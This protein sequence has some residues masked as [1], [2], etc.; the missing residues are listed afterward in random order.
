MSD[1]APDASSEHAMYEQ[2][3]RQE[4]AGP[5][6]FATRSM[7]E[8]EGSSLTA[9]LDLGRLGLRLA[10]EAGRYYLWHDLRASRA[11]ATRTVE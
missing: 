5:F 8:E 9:S 2:C 4:L 11:S 1:G 3:T 6:L 10:F 7:R